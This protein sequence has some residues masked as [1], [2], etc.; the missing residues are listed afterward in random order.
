MK[1]KGK[2]L[3]SF[4]DE[5]GTINIIDIE[6]ILKPRKKVFSLLL[7]IEKKEEII[8]KVY[9]LLIRWKELKM[10]LKKMKK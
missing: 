4:N 9:H 8:W 6:K 5:I 1:N 7:S 3:K 2:D 10:K